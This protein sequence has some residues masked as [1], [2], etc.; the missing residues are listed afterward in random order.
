MRTIIA[1]F[2]LWY[3]AAAA[4]GPS[5]AETPSDESVT[6]ASLSVF[7]EKWNKEANSRKIERMVREAASKG[8]RWIVTPEGALE[9]YVVNE[10]IR[11]KD[12]QRKA[13]LVKRFQ[14]LAEPLDGP[15]VLRFR[16][17]ADDLNVHL[18]LGMLEADG[19]KTFN[20]ALLIGPDGRIIGKYRKT[21]FHQGYDVNPPGYTP[22]DSYPVFDGG[23]I[24][25]G[26]M[27]C[28]D[29]QL[30]EPARALALGGADLILCPS[31]GGR[32]DWNTRLMQVRAYEN[33]T[34]VV[35]THPEQS[36][37][38]DR[39]GN[40]KAECGKDEIALYKIPLGDLTKTRQSVTRRRPATYGRLFEEPKR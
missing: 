24:R 19:D 10:V 15:Y 13:R 1:L 34:Y 33:Q 35:F 39:N 27:I 16:Q 32:G 40:V 26:V 21:H 18:L 20:T 17:L 2:V 11:E 28:F 31:Y 29:R 36:L 6:I 12:P 22:G 3:L 30:P 9:G 23:G 38:I 7:P 25:V 14:E 4:G 37:I 5:C 8:A